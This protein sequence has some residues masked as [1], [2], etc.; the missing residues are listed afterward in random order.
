MP[1]YKVPMEFRTLEIDK[2]K[3]T[4]NH[5]AELM[6]K[7]FTQK[8]D[9]GFRGWDHQAINE[10]WSLCLK[11]RLLKNLVNEDWV[12]VANL[13]LMLWYNEGFYDDPNKEKYDE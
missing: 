8:H 2:Y 1:T 13:A 9:E 5:F 12:D 10:Y 11:E 4:L 6:I 7:R 3:N